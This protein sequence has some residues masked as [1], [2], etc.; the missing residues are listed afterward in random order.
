MKNILSLFGRLVQSYIFII[1]IALILGL[2]FY[3]TVS[4]LAA[5]ATVFLQIIF[6]FTA[7]KLDVVKV[8]KSV[9]DVKLLVVVNGFM[10][11]VLPALVFI[12]ASQLAPSMAVAL[13]LLAAM[14]TGM[15]APLLT[16]VVG[17]KPG[18]TLILTITTSILS[19]ITIPIV[20]SIFA[21]TEVTVSF[22]TMFLDLA[23]V[24]IIPFFLAQVVRY[25]FNEKIK[26]TYFTF[27]PISL[28]LL[29]ALIAGVVAKQAPV[30]R[31]N[32]NQDMLFQLV[33]LSLFILWMLGIGYAI[34]FWRKDDIRVSVSVA[35]T[36]MNF[37]LAIYLAATFFSDPTVLLTTVMVIFP[38][39]LLV[40]P[41]K[42]LVKRFF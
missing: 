36:F 15:T 4:P 13:L 7:L 40:I 20:I 41:Y 33:F 23:Y 19:A 1:S 38:W 14:P 16:D 30:L 42:Y 25:F 18:V 12:I 27:K 26:T 5:F 8:L 17:G 2:F 37:T 31:E 21:S 3:E 29:G 24:I 28:I 11:L 9:S 32:L 34:V 35:T 10:L 39:S 22:F 6:F